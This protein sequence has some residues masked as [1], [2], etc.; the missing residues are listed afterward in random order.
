MS[1]TVMSR[2]QPFTPT[3]LST[4][5]SFPDLDSLPPLKNTL[6]LNQ[7]RIGASA[8]EVPRPP[9]WVMRQAGRYLPEFQAVRAK[10]SFFEVCETP[11]LA[12]EVTLQP[13]DRFA[14]LLDASIIFSD[15]LVVAKALGLAVEMKGGVGPHFPEPLRDGEDARRRVLSRETD[16]SKELGYVYD[17]VT[18]TRTK[19]DGRVPLIGFSAAPW[20]LFCYMAEGGGSKTWEKAKSWCYRDPESA[21]AILERIATVSAE[22]L[23]GQVRSGAQVS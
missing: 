6:L 7:A 23:A 13:I 15:I 1:T 11:E 17:A 5:Y 16:V 8:L 4:M 21:H 12:C 10:H 19:L 22:Y 14:G 3:Q 20:T 9:A 2:G 18:L